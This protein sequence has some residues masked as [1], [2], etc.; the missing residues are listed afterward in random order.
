M[1]LPI[2]GDPAP[3]LSGTTALGVPFDLAAPR[4]HRILIEFHRATW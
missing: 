3:A 1:T 4:E 2:V